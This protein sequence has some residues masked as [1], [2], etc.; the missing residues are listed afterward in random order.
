MAK[1]LLVGLSRHFSRRA[2]KAQGRDK[3]VLTL[4]VDTLEWLQSKVKSMKICEN[5]QCSELSKHFFRVY[6]NDRYC[7]RGCGVKA[8]ALRQAKRVVESEKPAKDFKKP[9]EVRR[10][11]SAGATKRWEKYRAKTGIPK[12]GTLV[13]KA[14]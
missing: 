14:R 7:C 12:Y 3:E 10:N 5:P 2:K 1:G 13:K 9:V 8:K 4:M 6:N 11:M